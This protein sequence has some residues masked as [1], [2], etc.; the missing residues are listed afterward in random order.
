[1]RVPHSLRV[2]LV[3][4]LAAAAACAQTTPN[5][6]ASPDPVTPS[7]DQPRPDSEKQNQ[8]T[9]KPNSGAQNQDSANPNE[10]QW[11]SHTV[12]DATRGTPYVELSLQ[13]SYVVG[14]SLVDDARPALVVQCANGKILGNF[15]SFGALLSLHVGGLYHVELQ[16]RIDNEKR[17]I[18]VDELSSDRMSAFFSRGDL[19]RVL[20]ARHV[21]VFAVEFAGP[22]M[23]ADFTMP[24]SSP[25]FAACGQDWVLN[26]TNDWVLQRK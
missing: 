19:K 18:I 4:V 17:H 16:T 20:D 2:L 9:D 25:I 26:H 10:P 24:R 1:M 6:Q 3:C 7:K 15:F 21:V 14:P 13:G 12:T 5:Q 8:D 11:T 22:Q 23:Q